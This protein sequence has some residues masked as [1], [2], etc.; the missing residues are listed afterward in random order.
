[1]LETRYL[2]LINQKKKNNSGDSNHLQIEHFKQNSDIVIIYEGHRCTGRVGY[3]MNRTRRHTLFVL[4]I[5]LIST[6]PFSP[7]AVA[8]DE[9]DPLN[10]Q[11]QDITAYFDPVS[12]TTTVNWTVQST[13]DATAQFIQQQEYRVYRSDAPITDVTLAGL[14][15]F[16]TINVCPQTMNA[17]DCYGMSRSVSYPVDPGVNG[18]FYYAVTTMLSNGT[19][20]AELILNESNLYEP[21][22]EITSVVQTPYFVSYEFDPSTSI[23]SLRWLNYNTVSPNTFP[24][25]GDD[26]LRIHIWRTDYQLDRTLGLQLASSTQPIANLSANYTSY[27]VVIPPET[28][29]ESYYSI[30]Y[31]LPNHSGPG[32]DYEDFRFLFENTMKEPVSEDNMPPAQ[33]IITFAQFVPE[34]VL[35]LADLG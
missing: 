12:E 3:P 16:E 32:Q 34:R 24:E 9:G 22:Q 1:M 7:G 25:T 26:A 35:S 19:E 2:N 29:R 20:A 5:L 17:F 23:T 4:A 21:I 11:A 6:I 18:S 8:Q 10:Y 15:P 13:I 28:E 31:Y 14:T 33:P 27:E 30:T